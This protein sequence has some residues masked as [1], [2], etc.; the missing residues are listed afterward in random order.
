MSNFTIS[1]LNEHQYAA[2]EAALREAAIQVLKRHD[3]LPDS[4]LTVAILNDEEVRA[5]N[6]QHRGVDAPTDVLSFPADALPDDFGEN[7][8]LGDIL[9]AY[10]YL[11]AQNE[12]E[13]YVMAESLLLMVVHGTLHLLGYDHLSSE[14]R[15]EMWSVQAEVLKELNIS[16]D[17]VPAYEQEHD[18]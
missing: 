8:Y 16:P 9:I 1:I 14:E 18:E 4:T 5:L 2:D 6:L 10:P 3:V 7:P 17:I 15:D 12:R 11:Q 13:G